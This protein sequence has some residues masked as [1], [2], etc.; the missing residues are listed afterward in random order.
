MRREPWR[1][2]SHNEHHVTV[3][4]R[5]RYNMSHRSRLAAAW[6]ERCNSYLRRAAR[7]GRKE[8]GDRALEKSPRIRE[9]RQR[10]S[11]ARRHTLRDNNEKILLHSK[12]ATHSTP[13]QR[14]FF[15]PANVYLA[16]SQP[17][18]PRN[19]PASSATIP[20]RLPRPPALALT[21]GGLRDD[22]PHG[23]PLPAHFRQDLRPAHLVKRRGG[24]E[25]LERD[26][27]SGSMP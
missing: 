15:A 27:S 18:R 1:E 9:S 13:R 7:P 22:L 10:T 16:P 26:G 4:L 24:S 11:G 23:F 21:A 6:H 12:Q 5:R 8:L 25:I 20:A 19:P 17:S 2:T 14:G 3:E